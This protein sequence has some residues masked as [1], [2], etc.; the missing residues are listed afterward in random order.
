MYVCA[1]ALEAAAPTLPTL[2]FYG[3]ATGLFDLYPVLGIPITVY[4]DLSS[5]PP[6]K[7]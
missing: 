7:T 5:F 2:F 3:L 6:V 1:S 4:M